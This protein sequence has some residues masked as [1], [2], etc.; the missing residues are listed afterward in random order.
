MLPPD[1]LVTAD[2]RAN[3]PSSLSRITTPRWKNVARK[4]PPD[5][6]RHQPRSGGDVAVL[7]EPAAPA[8]LLAACFPSSSP[9]MFHTPRR[10]RPH[11]AEVPARL[12]T[13]P[14]DRHQC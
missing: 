9:G 3:T 8:S 6:H 1:T 5:R 10:V 12:G 13:L 2:S 14:D 11:F 4:P 7:P